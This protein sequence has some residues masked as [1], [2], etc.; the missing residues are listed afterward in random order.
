MILISDVY[1]YIYL[2]QIHYCRYIFYHLGHDILEPYNIL[3]QVR[4]TTSKTKLDIW[5]SKLGI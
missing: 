1:L 4:F 2:F 3:T 5:Y